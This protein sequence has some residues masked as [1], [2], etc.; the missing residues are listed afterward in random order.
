MARGSTYNNQCGFL[1]NIF[2]VHFKSGTDVEQFQQDYNILNKLS[3]R[4]YN[5]N[6][7]QKRSYLMRNTSYFNNDG[8]AK[9]RVMS[10][11]TLVNFK[12]LSPAARSRH[13]LIDCLECSIKH[14][15]EW[16]L[17]NGNVG[18]AQPVTPQTA[19][20]TLKAVLEKTPEQITGK[21]VKE[22]VINV[23][24]PAEKIINKTPHSCKLSKPKRNLKRKSITAKDVPRKVRRQIIKAANESIS[25]QTINND[26]LALYSTKQSHSE[27]DLQ[28]KRQFGEFRANRKKSHIGNFRNYAF[29]LEVVEATLSAGN[30]T[31]WTQ[32]SKSA[33]LKNKHGEVPK[34]AGQVRKKGSQR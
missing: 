21:L 24:K 26:F 8:E 30:T 34:N 23:I 15:A 4:D 5:R 9:E 20:K 13:N 16:Q 12:K 22:F 6:R 17:I 31:N 11:F 7:K 29:D 18:I 28:R 19:V 2:F 32:L 14:K 33:N 1:T 10:Y 3:I 25:E 27:W